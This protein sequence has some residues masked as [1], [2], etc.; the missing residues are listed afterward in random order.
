MIQNDPITEKSSCYKNCWCVLQQPEFSYCLKLFML[1][2]K[3]NCKDII[4]GGAFLPLTLMTVIIEVKQNK[5]IKLKCSGI[6]VN[7]KKKYNL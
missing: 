6:G 7:I 2:N 3:R 1:K 4:A 5:R